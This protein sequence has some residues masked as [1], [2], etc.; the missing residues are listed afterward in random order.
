MTSFKHRQRQVKLAAGR[1]KARTDQQITQALKIIRDE[2]ND[3][4]EFALKEQ[5]VPQATIDL[6]KMKVRQ[7]QS[8]LD[9]Q[10]IRAESGLYR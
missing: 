5:G 4:W 10:F 3:A 2:N 9:D 8:T 7:Q 6:A 1:D